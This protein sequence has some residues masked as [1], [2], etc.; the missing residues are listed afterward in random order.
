MQPRD[1]RGQWVMIGSTVRFKTGLLGKEKAGE[2][3]GQTSGKPGFFDVTDTDGKIQSVRA[4]KLTQTKFAARLDDNDVDDDDLP[5]EPAAER[6]VAPLADPN[7]TFDSGDPARVN[8]I[9][10]GLDPSRVRVGSMVTP[11]RLPNGVQI[12]VP[13]PAANESEEGYVP[14]QPSNTRGTVIDGGKGADGKWRFLVDVPGR[15]ETEVVLNDGQQVRVG[16]G[17]G[18]DYGDWD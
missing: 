16:G 12:D 9:R 15:G 8:P 3:T 10:E 4:D 17:N 1:A 11:D 7:P 13:D 2:V 18:D 6:T 14:T 5:P